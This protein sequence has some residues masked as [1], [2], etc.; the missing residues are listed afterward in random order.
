MGA[1]NNP[2][3]KDIPADPVDK[4]DSTP[5]IPG[6]IVYRGHNNY[7]AKQAS[8]EATFQGDYGQSLTVQSQA[9]DADINVL[10]RR[11]GLT[12]KMP[13]N[14]YTPTYGDFEDITDYASALRAIRHAE[15]QFATIPAEVRARFGNDPQR[16]LEF[17]SSE[18]NWDEM[19]KLGLT[20]GPR[21]KPPVEAPPAPPQTPPGGQQST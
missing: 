1:I 2:Y 21:P 15:E 12:G 8:D 13:D 18:D 10:M 9:E 7:D 3:D 5:A 19:H 16:F 20:K 4:D 14:P 6:T 17:T 11:Y